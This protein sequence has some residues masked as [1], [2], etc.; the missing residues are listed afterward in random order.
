MKRDIQPLFLVGD[1]ELGAAIGL[2][3]SESL[4]S[5]RDEG[6]PYYHSGKSFVY[7]PDEVKTFL[8]KLWQTKRVKLKTRTE[9]GKR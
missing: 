3:T 6:L 2:S 5:L 7:D 9:N 8:K 1:K 4:K